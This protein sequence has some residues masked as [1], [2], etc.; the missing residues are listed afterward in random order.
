MNVLIRREFAEVVEAGREVREAVALWEAVDAYSKE[1]RDLKNW[2]PRLRS[3]PLELPRG[4][5]CPAPEELN[6][7]A[8]AQSPGDREKFTTT[9][10]ERLEMCV[11]ASLAEYQ[12]EVSEV[13]ARTEC[14]PMDGSFVD[15]IAQPACM[16]IEHIEHL[17]AVQSPPPGVVRWVSDHKDSLIQ[18]IVEAARLAEERPQEGDKFD[19]EKHEYPPAEVSVGLAMRARVV[20]VVRPGYRESGSRKLIRKARV[21]VGRE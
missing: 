15:L 17:A 10:R 20:S 6:Q 4:L 12:K 9:V 19:D 2:L 13:L 7:Q 8:R 14:E 16:V 11:Q 1:M 3:M 21:V 5:D 18:E